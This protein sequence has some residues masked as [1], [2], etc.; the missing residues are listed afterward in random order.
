M[1]INDHSSTGIKQSRVSAIG[2]PQLLAAM[3][4]INGMVLLNQRE[5]T[6]GIVLLSFGLVFVAFSRTI[7][8][9]LKRRRESPSNY[10]AWVI[11]K[12]D[13]VAR[14]YGEN[15]E[16]LP[17]SS[18]LQFMKSDYADLQLELDEFMLLSILA[19][20]AGLDV[21]YL[22]ESCL[23]LRSPGVLKLDNRNY[24]PRNAFA[25]ILLSL[26]MD[27]EFSDIPIR[28]WLIQGR[29]YLFQE[30]KPDAPAQQSAS[31][32]P[33]ESTSE[34]GAPVSPK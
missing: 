24:V 30:Q 23:S 9:V 20:G 3:L 17:A 13:E 18:Y 27:A 25:R 21:L 12:I 11:S 10:H 7:A 31:R 19:S 2:L 8:L 1:T 5:L 33:E 28:R 14:V 34:S 4:V 15:V 29:R 26:A 6:G 32:I 22:L 16:K